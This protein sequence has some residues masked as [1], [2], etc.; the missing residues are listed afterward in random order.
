RA[1]CFAERPAASDRGRLLVMRLHDSYPIG[2]QVADDPVVW[3]FDDFL[4]TEEREHVI[5]VARPRLEA[6]KVTSTK[7]NTVSTARTGSVAWVRYGDS[8]MVQGVMH[9][10]SDLVGIPVHH[11]ESMQVV[12]YAETQ[13]YRPHF[14]GWDLNTEKGRLRTENGGQRVLTALMYLNDVEGGGGTSFPK[15]DLEVE[16]KPGRLVIFHNIVDTET[17]LHPHSLHGGMPVTAGE[18]WACNL[19][20][21]A[22]PYRT[23]ADRVAKPITASSR[24]GGGQPNRASRRRAKK[25]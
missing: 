13:E 8:P 20:F 24:T 9:R 11:S 12:H 22:R 4:S 2:E 23:G 16:S 6:A 3:V 1:T 19:W 25:R 21:R 17:N 10:V 15:L 14:D 18:K 7:V 5:G